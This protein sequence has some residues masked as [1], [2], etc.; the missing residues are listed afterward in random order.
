MKKQI[1]LTILALSVVLGASQFS[2]AQILIDDFSTGA[3]KSPE[4]KTGVHTSGQNGSMLG[5]NRSTGFSICKAQTCAT[6]NP[7]K[8]A[9]SYAFLP[10]TTAA[11]AAMIQSVGYGAAPRI[12]MGYGFGAPM[13][14]D[15]SSTDRIQINFRGLSQYLNFNL[16]VFTGTSWGQNGCNLPPSTAPF[17][18]EL[19]YTGFTG[20]G[21][22]KNHVNFLNFIF[23][24]GSPIGGVNFAIASIR[25]VNGGAPGAIVC[26]LN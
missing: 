3:Y 20:P 2:R 23:Q 8:Q 13:D 19:P 10:T 21:F 18:V 24:D 17:T 15:F 9:M 25:A 1:T 6:V 7:Y 4:F 22:D 14:Q 12:D 11:P 26:H 5:L 16:Q